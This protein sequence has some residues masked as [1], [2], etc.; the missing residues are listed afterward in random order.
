M[1][2]KSVWTDW[3][4]TETPQSPKKNAQNQPST[5]TGDNTTR[6]KINPY[7][8]LLLL[9]SFVVYALN[10]S[11]VKR[12]QTGSSSS[13]TTTVSAPCTRDV[14]SIRTVSCSLWGG[15]PPPAPTAR[16]RVRV[17]VSADGLSVSR[18]GLSQD[19]QVFVFCWYISGIAVLYWHCYVKKK[20]SSQVNEI[21]T[22]SFE[23]VSHNLRY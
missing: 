5:H 12:L 6:G 18:R 14:P 3:S 4:V 9:F 23:N 17:R 16:S 13:T 11:S 10:S 22:V 20:N 19:Q 15:E 7:P 21:T 2:M 8:R 1:S